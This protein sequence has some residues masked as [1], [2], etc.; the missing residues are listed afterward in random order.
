MENV[1]IISQKGKTAFPVVYGVFP[2]GGAN[3]VLTFV[4][5]NIRDE[6]LTTTTPEQLEID[7]KASLEAYGA[8]IDAFL[9]NFMG[10]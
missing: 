2:P 4:L 6:V 8:R 5:K 9:Q 7:V 1:H 3:E 10:H